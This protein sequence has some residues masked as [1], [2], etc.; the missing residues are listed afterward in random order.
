VAGEDG[1]LGEKLMRRTL[2]H[3]KTCARLPVFFL[4][5]GNPCWTSHMAASHLIM[6]PSMAC[7]IN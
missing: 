5:I 4:L 3:P 2:C 1:K 6:H 7:A